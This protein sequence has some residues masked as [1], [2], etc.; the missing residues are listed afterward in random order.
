M[1]DQVS[2]IIS[3]SLQNFYWIL[4][5]IAAALILLKIFQKSGNKR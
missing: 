2:D 3:N 1:N 4:I 5:C